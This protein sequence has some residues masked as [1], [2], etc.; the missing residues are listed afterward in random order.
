MKPKK[1]LLIDDEEL[2]RMSTQVCLEVTANWEVIVAASGKEG[3]L[4]AA[5]QQ[6]DVILLD[7]S[8]PEMNGITTF[9][10][11]QNNQATSHI[12]VILLT[13]KVQTSDRQEFIDLGITGVIVKPYDPHSLASQIAAALGW[14]I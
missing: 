7:I 9:E 5:S 6:P 14:N 3:L 8:M 2:I 12:P 13:A 1:I 11:L 4:L 10:Y